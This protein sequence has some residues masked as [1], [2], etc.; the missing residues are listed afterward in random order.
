MISAKW[1]AAFVCVFKFVCFC[2]YVDVNLCVL[3]YVCV[4]VCVCVWPYVMHVSVDALVCG[5]M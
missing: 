3:V 4:C 1:P 2:V 5:L